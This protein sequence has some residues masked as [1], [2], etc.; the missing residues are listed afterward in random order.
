MIPIS[1]YS[2]I[3]TFGTVSFNIA[4]VRVSKI[5]ATSK[6]KMGKTYAET[7]IVG[8]NALDTILEVEGVIVGL[9]QTSA[10][11]RAQAIETDRAALEALEDGM[12]RVYTDGKHSGNFVIKPG[13]F[14]W[15]DDPARASG[16]PYPFT[17]ILVEWQ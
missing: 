17:F 9:S 8:K 6:T 4:P 1:E 10:Q 3:A 16:E 2:S 13:S 15:P 12:Y 14:V 11:T 5:S 7:P